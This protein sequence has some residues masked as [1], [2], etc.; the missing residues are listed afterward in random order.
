MSNEKFHNCGMLHIMLQQR[1]QTK[2]VFQAN[3]ESK[4]STMHFDLKK[5][6]LGQK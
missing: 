4:T 3:T 2:L 6:S 1:N 5:T